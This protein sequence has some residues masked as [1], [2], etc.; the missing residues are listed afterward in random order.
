MVEFVKVLILSAGRTIMIIGVLASLFL[1]LGY[2]LAPGMIKG[3]S[4]SVNRIFEIDD[5]M[6]GHKLFVGILFM[7]ITIVLAGTLIYIK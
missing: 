6:I 3:L 7:L 5:W 2:L 4:G 1:S